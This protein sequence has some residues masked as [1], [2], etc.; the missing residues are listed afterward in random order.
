MSELSPLS[1]VKLKSDFGAVR[2]AFDPFVW[3]GRAL[4]AE[5]EKMEGV[6][7]AH[8]YP[9]LSWSVCAPGHHGYPRAPDL[10]LG[11]A[12]RGRL[13]HQITGAPARPFLHLLKSNSQTSAGMAVHS[14]V[15]PGISLGHPLGGPERVDP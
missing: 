8:L 3:T 7:L 13:G 14:S 11:K 4:Q 10:I 6:G 9:A 1:G 5:C 15:A 12:L 2:A